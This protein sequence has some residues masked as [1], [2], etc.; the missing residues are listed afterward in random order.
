MIVVIGL[1]YVGF[2]LAASLSLY[3]PVVGVDKDRSKAEELKKEV[4]NFKIY[5]NS[6]YDIDSID[7]IE[8]IIVCVPT[9]V[10]K[11][12]I[13]DLS[14]LDEASLFAGTLLKNNPSAVVVYESTVFP[15]CTEGH[16]LPILKE[17]SGLENINLGYSPERI[18]PGDKVNTLTTITKIIS[19]NNK[20]SL[21]K[22][23]E[24]YSDV[25]LSLYKAGSIRIAESA[26]IIE[27]TQ[28]DINIGLMNELAMIF[29]KMKIPID[30]VLEAAGTKWNFHDYKPGL[31]GGHC[32][33][34][35]PYYLT[36]AAQ[37]CDLNPEMILAG[38]RV[39]DRMASYIANFV[40]KLKP[41]AVG[42]LGATFKP[43]VGDFRNSK[44]LELINELSEYKK[45][46]IMTHDPFDYDHKIPHN[47][48]LEKFQL[49]DVIIKAVDHRFYKEIDYK[50]MLRHGG[51]VF[52]VGQWKFI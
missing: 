27:N 35:D 19:A 46:E 6:E 52:D 9:P 31:V 13:P 1:G 17:V 51:K 43:N 3:H 5:E 18:N 14:A 2:P 47:R 4:S 16:C 10:N 24:I 26:K 37:G 49:C 38:R 50:P 7:N 23:E 32:I 40:M 29:D 41:K 8:M 30:E 11:Y 28:R 12:K 22:M 20:E 33:G 45:L 39:N 34:V 42:V 36:Y 44:S 15:D 48:P 21:N 25:C